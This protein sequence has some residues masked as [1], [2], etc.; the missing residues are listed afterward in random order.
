MNKF[1]ENGLILLSFGLV[2]M[3]HESIQRDMQSVIDTQ[4]ELLHDAACDN[5][6][7][8]FYIHNKEVEENA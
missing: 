1:I 8:R 5:M 2:V 6:A 4:A 3:L 7:L